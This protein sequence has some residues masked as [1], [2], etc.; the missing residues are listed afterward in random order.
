[1]G[2]PG[3]GYQRYVLAL[4]LAAYTLNAFDRSIVNL[5]LE[6]IGREFG[7][8]DA[9]LGLLSGP[10]FALFYSTLAIP[11]AMLA[12]RWSRRNTLVLSVLVWSVMTS[13]Y[14]FAGSFVALVLARIGVAVGEAGASPA[15]HSMIAERFPA[16]RRATALGIYTLGA[17]AGAVLAGLVGG[18][19][20]EHLGW[21]GTMVLAG[22]PGLLLVPLLLLIR[23]PKPAPAVRPATPAFAKT[24]AHFAS[25]PT[26]RHLCAACALHSMAMYASSSFNPTYLARS[27][28][29][30]GSEIGTLVALTGVSGMAGTYLGGFLADR[31]G[32]RRGEPRWPLWVSAL[33]SLAVIPVQLVCYLGSGLPMTVA[34]LLSSL[35]SFVFFGPSYAVAQSVATPGTRA[36]AAAVV[37]FFKSFVGMGAGPVLVGLL[38]DHLAP[39]AGDHSL[40]WGLLLAPALNLWAAAHFLLAA[41]AVRASPPRPAAGPP[42]PRP[43]P[44]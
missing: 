12:D 19:G 27:H 23:E 10:A 16:E 13:L 6:P 33:A 30:L 32:A 14:G 25:I 2:A 15:S 7:A 1:M 31:L 39:V 44:R 37:L 18:W 24:M 40:R 20:G 35:L 29:W 22:V 28:G 41:H 21:R 3:P 11:I 36:T 38:S 17:P 8:S 34:F 4:L 43:D 5:L 9:Q 26:F 42:D